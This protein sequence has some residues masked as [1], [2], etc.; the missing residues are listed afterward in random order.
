MN[1]ATVRARLVAL[2]CLAA[3]LFSPPLVV[4]F[5]RSSTGSVSWLSLYL[6]AAWTSTIALAAWLMERGQGDE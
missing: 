3:L 6:F 2:V 4:V 5:D 1:G